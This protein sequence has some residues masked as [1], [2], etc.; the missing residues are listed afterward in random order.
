MII[1]IAGNYATSSGRA[2]DPK[3]ERLK[4]K[5]SNHEGIR[6]ELKG[7]KYNKRNQKA[8]ID[9]YCDESRTGNEDKD[10]AEEAVDRRRASDDE[11]EEPADDNKSLH[12]ISYGPDDETDILRLDWY[13]KY[14]CEDAPKGDDDDADDDRKPKSAGW[15][16]FTWFIVM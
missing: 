10:S 11:T 7:G 12:F 4:A 14:A 3:Y 16:F 9:F 8:V 6:M 15:G 13:T 2:L 1:P 5:D